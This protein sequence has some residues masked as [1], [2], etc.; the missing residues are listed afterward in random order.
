MRIG[1]STIAMTSQRKYS[2]YKSIQYAEYN[3][4]INEMDILLTLKAKKKVCSTR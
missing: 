2:E 3:G 1:G 4:L